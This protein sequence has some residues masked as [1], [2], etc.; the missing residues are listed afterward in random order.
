[1]RGQREGASGKG[2]KRGVIK[3][4]QNKNSPE[5]WL[6]MLDT[7]SSGSSLAFMKG[8]SQGQGCIVSNDG[9]AEIWKEYGSLIILLN[10]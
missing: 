1:M 7:W 3:Q 8:A 2:C 10:H 9:R 4:K 6:S 5:F